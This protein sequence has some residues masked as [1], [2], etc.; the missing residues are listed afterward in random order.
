MTAAATHASPFTRTA[1]LLGLL[2]A[3][4]VALL[5]PVGLVEAWAR[6]PAYDGPGVATVVVIGAAVACSLASLAGLLVLH[7]AHWWVWPVA[8]LTVLAFA[9]APAH[10]DAGDWLS[11]AAL[12][13]LGL[14]VAY[15]RVLPR[16]AGLAFALGTAAQVASEALAIVAV[17]VALYGYL[18]LV[19]AMWRDDL[20]PPP[21]PPVLP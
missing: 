20:E 19:W 15:A 18:T 17:P 11:S 1:G 4:L 12:A 2:T 13:L 8:L 14:G 3:P 9:V 21:V 10:G 6:G 16:H 5:F 7:R